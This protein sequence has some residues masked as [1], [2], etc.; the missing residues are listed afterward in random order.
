MVP[1]IK[2]TT[3]NHDDHSALVRSYNR[4]IIPRPQVRLQVADP[5][6][7]IVGVKLMKQV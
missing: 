4:S 6:K 7:A 3:P 5:P 1:V 2:L